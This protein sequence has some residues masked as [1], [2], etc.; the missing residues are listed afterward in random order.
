[1]T[2]P[3]KTILNYARFS[4]VDAIMTVSHFR[5]T[6]LFLNILLPLYVVMM[7]I[8]VY[9]PTTGVDTEPA[10]TFSLFIFHA[11]KRRTATFQP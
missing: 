8:Y 1:M 3:K 7:T 10:F 5:G 6:E 2:R 9:V 11:M 4:F